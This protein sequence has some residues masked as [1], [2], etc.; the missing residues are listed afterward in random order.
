VCS[1]DAM[2][3]VVS[4]IVAV[5]GTLAGSAMAYVFAERPGA[6]TGVNLAM[7]VHDVNGLTRTAASTPR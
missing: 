5:L 3:N 6:E 1:Y 7:R 2:S 4:S